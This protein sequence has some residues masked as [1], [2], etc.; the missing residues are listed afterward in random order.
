MVLPL[1]RLKIETAGQLVRAI[2]YTA[3][4]PRDS[5]KVRAE[6][7]KLS[8]AARTKLNAITS[9]NKCRLV[10]A[11][12]FS[13]GDLFVTLTYSDAALPTT[14]RDALRLLRNWIAKMRTEYRRSGSK[15]DYLYTTENAHG[16]GRYHHHVIARRFPGDALE[17]MQAHWI[18][19][20]IHLDRIDTTDFTD[21]SKYFS[22]EA[23]DKGRKIGQRTWTPSHGLKKPEVISISV[24][25]NYRLDAP[26]GSI[27]IDNPSCRN[28]Y[29]EYSY[30]EYLAPTKQVQKDA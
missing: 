15:F 7:R 13:V 3:H 18:Q 10:M 11:A 16:D 21:L 2:C 14:R 23:G 22:K 28:Q 30:L 6:K 5:E 27:V 24:H 1:K 4:L 29:G 20:Q 9:W 17:V 26:P 25:D 8:S 12:N 19:G